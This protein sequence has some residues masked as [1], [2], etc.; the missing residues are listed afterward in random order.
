MSTP[1]MH[2]SE[3]QGP[4]PASAEQARLLANRL[5]RLGSHAPA[6]VMRP[7]LDDV[8]SMLRSLVAAGQHDAVNTLGAAAKALRIPVQDLDLLRSLAFVAQGDTLG[9]REALKEELRYFPDNETARRMME[10]L[11]GHDSRTETVADPD[12]AAILP[13]IRA[14]TMVGLPRLQSL[15]SLAKQVCLADLPGD[16]AECGVAA[17]GSSALLAYAIRR[18]SRRPRTLYCFD[19]FSGMPDPGPQD[20]HRG[21]TAQ[22]SG[23]GAGTCAA[24]VESLLEVC[25]LLGLEDLVRPFPGF[26]K[27]TLPMAAREIPALALLHMDGDWYES[28]MD[29]LNNFYDLVTPQAPIQVDDFGY[30]EGCDRALAD[31][32]T[33]RGLSLAVKR[34][35]GGVGAVFLKPA[36]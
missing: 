5:Y 34:I 20:V 35:P 17:G 14:Y 19:T 3:V 7:L 23:W 18:Y 21:I 33:A 8:V 10:L 31:F 28:T 22:E 9:A 16:F 27:D 29:I 2:R 4:P 15:F 36:A 13:V 11:Q 32:A 25:R 12:L 30:W 24:P 26:F 1:S 6:Q